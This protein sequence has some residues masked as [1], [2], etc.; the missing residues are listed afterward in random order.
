MFNIA[1]SHRQTTVNQFFDLGFGLPN[2]DFQKPYTSTNFQTQGFISPFT[3]RA[4][5]K[6][7][8]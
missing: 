3:S 6:L 5:V 8:F 4:S 7:Q 2:A 1:N